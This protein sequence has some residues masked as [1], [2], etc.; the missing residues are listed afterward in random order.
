MAWTRAV[1]AVKASRT[2]GVLPAL[3]PRA[4]GRAQSPRDREVDP[5]REWAVGANAVMWSASC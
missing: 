5:D 4:T 2:G 3:A 1:A